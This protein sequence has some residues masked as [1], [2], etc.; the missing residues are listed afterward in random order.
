MIK[1]N[2]KDQPYG[3]AG[4]LSRDDTSAIQAAITAAHMAGGGS[5]YLPPGKYW[6]SSTLIMYPNVSI[7][8][9]GIY[10]SIMAPST[11]GMVVIS[12]ALDGVGQVEFANFSIDC[13]IHNVAGVTGIQT[14]QVWYVQIRNMAFIGCRYNFTFDRGRFFTIENI[15]S[16]GTSSLKVGGVKIHSSDK[17]DRIFYVRMFGYMV[18]M[19]GAGLQPD[20]IC[21]QNCIAGKFG[22][23][24]FRDARAGGAV[25]AIVVEDNCQGVQIHDSIV[26]A[27]SVGIVVA[28]VAAGLVPEYTTITNV[29]IDQSDG[30]CAI[31]IGRGSRWT[32]ING[33]SITG[34]RGDRPNNGCGIL[35]QEAWYV[36]VTNL[37]V[38]GYTGPD[39]AGINIANSQNINVSNNIIHSA[40]TGIGILDSQNGFNIRILL[41]QFT[42]CGSPLNSNSFY[43]GVTSAL[44]SAG[45][46]G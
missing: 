44:N 10:V 33:G 1:I 42:Q 2:V 24:N 23:I 19:T 30:P 37:I 43:A 7:S 45:N 46:I 35:L 27:P 11:P 34:Y 28:S 40:S 14:V 29:D 9:D 39:A 41:N 6:V 20:N 26:A 31:L 12:L 17:N 22:Q 25:N 36:N 21:I 32:T 16:Q 38:S 15:N 18:D 4:D 13:G 8:G 3:A 5:V